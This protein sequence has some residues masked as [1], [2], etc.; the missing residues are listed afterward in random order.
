MLNS[1]STLFRHD[2]KY[3]NIYSSIGASLDCQAL[4]LKMHF[5]ELLLLTSSSVL[6]FIPQIMN[7]FFP[8]ASDANSE[9]AKIQFLQKDG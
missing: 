6:V 8:S 2:F 9:V 3:P 4:I 1:L 7:I 5:I